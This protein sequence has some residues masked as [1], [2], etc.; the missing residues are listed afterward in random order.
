MSF[1]DWTSPR[2]GRVIYTSARFATAKGWFTERWAGWASERG[3]DA[4]ADLS[5]ACKYGSIF[6][7]SVFGG[8]I[9]G[10]YEH[11][12]NFIDGRIV[13]LSH[14]ALDVGRMRHPYLH[15]PGYFEVPRLQA[16]L[17]ACRPRAERWA[18]EFVAHCRVIDDQRPD[19]SGGA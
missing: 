17:S 13:D 19:R 7:Q 8:S 3:L 10:H 12:Y 1:V 14:D 16:S 18:T 5:G 4:T 9:R 11:Q 2:P 15:E 6:M